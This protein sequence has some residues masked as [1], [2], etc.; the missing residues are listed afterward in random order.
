MFEI[1]NDAP[2]IHRASIHI[3]APREKIW[4]ILCN[5]EAWPK[6]NPQVR[7]ATLHGPLAPGT[8]FV[9]Q[10]GPGTIRSTLQSVL[11][12]REIAWTGSTLGIRAVH[13]WR[14]ESSGEETLVTTEESWSGILASLFR[15]PFHKTLQQSIEAG[16]RALSVA[17]EAPAP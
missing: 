12:E 9:W 15:G 16:L 14:M 7:R 5:I 17:A 8:V 2:V 1:D 3:A 10:A 4:S 11:P 6:W 13:V